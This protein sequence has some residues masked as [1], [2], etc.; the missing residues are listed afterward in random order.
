MVDSAGKQQLYT[1]LTDAVTQES[2]SVL[3][4]SHDE[5]ARSFATREITF[6][7]GRAYSP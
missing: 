6:N 2:I 4:V 1:A 7:Q 5:E 3:V